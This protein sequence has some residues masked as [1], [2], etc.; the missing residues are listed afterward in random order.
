[1]S[2]EAAIRLFLSM[3]LRSCMHGLQKINLTANWHREAC[4]PILSEKIR[5]NS[6]NSRQ[7]FLLSVLIRG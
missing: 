6:R 5:D 1:M 3:S 2:A 4:D 7:S